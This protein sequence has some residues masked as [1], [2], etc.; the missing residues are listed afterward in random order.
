MI[1][2]SYNGTSLQSGGIVT[3]DTTVYSSPKKTIQAEKL[4]ESDGSVIVKET[5]ESKV[6]T[7]DGI[8]SASTISGLDTLLD[9][10]KALL[11]N[12]KQNFDI[13]YAGSTRRYVATPQNVII[14]R[15]RGLNRAGWSVEFF[16]ESP[17]GSDTTSSTL[18]GSTVVTSSTSTS[19]VTV[20]GS[21]KAEPD[22]TV[23]VTS[24]TGG[25]PNKTIT[26]ANG[27]DLKGISITRTWTAGDVL[28]IDCMNK[29]VYVNNVATA[30]SGLFPSWDAG[31]GS[32]T[33]IDD[34]T[35]RSVTLSATYTK[36]FL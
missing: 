34:F 29:T 28:E 8:V 24:V 1:A 33:Y 6:F 26:I 14:T 5:W 9:T 7:C 13:D 23:T 17:V 36:R 31:T 11:N 16:C 15:E 27:T 19:A 25:S 2:V 18:L 3:T 4:A 35:T 10:F 12:R 30:S 20:G 21:Y 22:I 32:L